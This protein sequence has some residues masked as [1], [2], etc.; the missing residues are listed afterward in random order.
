MPTQPSLPPLI[1]HITERIAWEE[2]KHEGAYR[3]DTLEDEGFIHCSTS[4]QVVR[5]ANERFLNREGLVLL[6]IDPGRVKPE[7]RFEN[8][9]G[10]EA[11]F[12]HVYG[13]LNLDSVAD[14]LSF[15]PGEDGRFVLPI[16][17]AR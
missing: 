14:V 3:G 7:I 15:S 13:P 9:E 12:P 16:I 10:G 1:L 5:V 2:A 4:A 8:L 11:L 17:P 6:C